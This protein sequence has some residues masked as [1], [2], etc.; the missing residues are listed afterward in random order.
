MTDKLSK[1]V[2]HPFLAAVYPIL[3][4][5]SYNIAQIPPA[6]AARP[7]LISFLVALFLTVLFGAAAKDFRQGGLSVSIILMLFFTYGHVYQWLEGN[8]PAF[9]DH[10]LLG[11]IW[12]FIFLTGLALKWKIRDIGNITKYLNIIM[13]ALLIQPVFNIALFVS[14]SGV[15]ENIAPPSPFKNIKPNP[16]ANNGLPDIYYIILDGYGRSDVTQELFGFDNSSFIKY[17]S[18]RGFYVAEQSHSNYVPTSLSLSS[19]LN[20]DYLGGAEGQLIQSENRDSLAELIQH[21]KLRKFL[22]EQG[23]QT[24]TFATGYAPTTI[25]DSDVF[26]PYKANLVNDLEGLLL[27]TSALRAMGDRTQNLFIPFLCDVQRGGIN[28]ILENLK[29]VPELPGPKFVFAHILSPHPPFVFDKNGKDTKH[30]HC[31]G[32]DG[33]L[34]KGT[35]EDYHKGY[36]QQMAYISRK[37]QEVVDEILA[38]SNTP[39]IIII[40]S[41]H[42]SGLLLDWSSSKN[43]CLRERTSIL[44]AYYIPQSNV[45]YESIT[46]V[47]SFRVVLNEV[48]DLRLPLLE[49]RSYYSLWETPYQFEDITQKIEAKCKIPEK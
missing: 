36:P 28:N 24:V 3:F 15:P 8:A 13:L 39:P 43:S 33:S 44:N 32:L 41:D 48:F 40:Q 35:F 2:L 19:S 4:L 16:Q 34:F 27:A 49:D 31:N 5:L 6:Q 45:L 10:L 12:M 7:L 46:P 30:G 23:Y 17:L 20:L 14:R 42:G 29:R 26:I 9:A 1:Y 25:T 37:I 18:E 47:N 21:S 38:G 11:S 22:E